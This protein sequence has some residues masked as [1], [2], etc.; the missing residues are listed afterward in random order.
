MTCYDLSP[1]GLNHVKRM[2]LATEVFYEQTG[3]DR[4]GKGQ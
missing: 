3:E 1:F 2:K 4:Q